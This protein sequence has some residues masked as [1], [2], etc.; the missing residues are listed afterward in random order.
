M[1]KVQNQVGETFQDRG[2]RASELGPFFVRFVVGFFATSSCSHAAI[3]LRSIL[4]VHI[5]VDVVALI[6]L[7]LQIAE[8]T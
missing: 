2:Y 3:A 4:L 7:T 6:I 8:W 5:Q 1:R